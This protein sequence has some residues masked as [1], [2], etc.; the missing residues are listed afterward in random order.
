MTSVFSIKL[1]KKII[2]VLAREEV[3]L[4]LTDGTQASHRQVTVPSP[5]GVGN[6]IYTTDSKE[7]PATDESSISDD[8]EPITPPVGRARP[9][10]RHQR[11]QRG[12]G[13]VSHPSNPRSSTNSRTSHRRP[14]SV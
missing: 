12:S 5:W 7:G 6:F 3:E 8:S 14:G 13:L 11:R 2:S 9:Q 1:K 10:A 4:E